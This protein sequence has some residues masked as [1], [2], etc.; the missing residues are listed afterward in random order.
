MPIILNNTNVSCKNDNLQYYMV[1]PE[2]IVSFTE[3]FLILRSKAT[4]CNSLEEI[5]RVFGLS[6]F[7]SQNSSMERIIWTF[8]CDCIYHYNEICNSS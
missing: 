3:F 5:C 4:D 8:Y 7:V 6:I 2:F 1:L